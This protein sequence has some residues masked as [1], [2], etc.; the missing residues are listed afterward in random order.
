MS[1]RNNRRKSSLTTG[2]FALGLSV[3]AFTV[4]LIYLVL[5]LFEVGLTR[6]EIFAVIPPLLTLLV[7]IT[8][9]LVSFYALSEQRLMRQAGT[10]PVILIHLDNRE[11]ARI[12]STLEVRNVG[13]GAALNVRLS[14]LSEITEYL[15]D[16]IITDFSKV[17]H[18][19]RT[20]PQGHS[21]SYNFGVGH[22]LLGEPEIPPIEFEVTYENIE[23]VVQSSRQFIDVRELKMQR[24]D[25]GLNSRLAK[26]TERT[27]KALEG[28]QGMRPINAITQTKAEKTAEAA[29]LIEHHK[30]KHKDK[31]Y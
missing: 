11:D 29:A 24:A 10:D 13:A 16:R 21:I 27:A 23:G 15:P 14:L 18:A 31:G 20:I 1:L 4:V 9:L 19:F 8:S 6:T 17:T 25:D 5:D 22:E 3:G 26:A 12:L 28:M 7:A 30:Q 2:T